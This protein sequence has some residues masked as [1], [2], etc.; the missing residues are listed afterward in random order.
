M[1]SLAIHCKNQHGVARGGAGQKDNEGDGNEVNDPRTFRMMI[2]E[3]AG[4]RPCPFEGCSV[5][6][7]TWTS[8]WMHFWHRHV[9]D[10]VVILEEGNI[11]HQR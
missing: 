6:A 8:M 5:Q 4:P 3:K 9:Q 10:T 2:P 1:V 7:A 11:P